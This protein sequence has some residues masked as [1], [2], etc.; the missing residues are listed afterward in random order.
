[1]NFEFAFSLVNLSVMPA[2]FMLLVLPRWWVTRTLGAF[3][4]LPACFGS[5]IYN[6]ALSG[7]VWHGRGRWRVYDD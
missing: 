3:H 4:A 5:G 1:M 7:G 2:W 6:R